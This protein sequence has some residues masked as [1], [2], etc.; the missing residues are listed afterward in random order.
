MAHTVFLLVSAGQ[1]VLLD[2]AVHIVLHSRS[3]H[4]AVL[5]LAVHGLRINVILL[6]FVLHQPTLF[7]EFL[8]I[9]GGAG[10]YALVVFAHIG[11]E[12]NFGL[13]DVVE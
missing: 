8:E 5:R 2:Y 7:L 4:K 11:R 3:N 9:L 1:F 10:I 6:V 12:I 13:D